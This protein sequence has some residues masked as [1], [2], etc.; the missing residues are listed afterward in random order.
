VI[1][2]LVA[3]DDDVNLV[4]ELTLRLRSRGLLVR[5]R[6]RGL[7]YRGT[8]LGGRPP[9]RNLLEPLHS[10]SRGVLLCE[11]QP[12]HTRVYG[13]VV[14]WRALGL[15]LLVALLWAG[16]GLGLGWLRGAIPW[17]ALALGPGLALGSFVALRVLVH[18][19]LREEITGL[20]G[21]MED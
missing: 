12:D 9:G 16:A 5:P 10:V 15:A 8:W 7:E 2:V 4:N 6:S 17:G 20:G 19:R 21:S 11:R 18:R 13:E 14:Q 1:D 3:T